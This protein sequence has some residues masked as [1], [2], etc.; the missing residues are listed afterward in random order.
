MAGTD[1]QPSRA[2]GPIDGGME[3][4]GPAPAGP[5]DRLL[6]RPPFPPA[7]D[8]CALTGVES[9]ISTTG[10]PS[11]AANSVNTRSHTPWRAQRTNRLYSVL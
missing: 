10:G 4:G 11:A 7:A 8:R 3:F 2:T 1:E 5:P 9:N 6:L